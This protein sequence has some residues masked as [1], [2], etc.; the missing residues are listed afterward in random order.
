MIWN[1]STYVLV[2]SL[3]F[4]EKGFCHI[5]SPPV[6]SRT[7]WPVRLPTHQPMAVVQPSWL[8]AVDPIQTVLISVQ[9]ATGCALW[10]C[11][12]TPPQQVAVPCQQRKDAAPCP[13][14][15]SLSPKKNGFQVELWPEELAPTCDELMLNHNWSGCKIWRKI[16][17]DINYRFEWQ[18][19]GCSVWPWN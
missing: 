10:D 9:R 4:A 13:Q 3:I 8:V 1:E 16:F 5:C 19:V 15:S 12:A 17:Q 2:Y 14:N 18:D 6:K 11:L 7:M